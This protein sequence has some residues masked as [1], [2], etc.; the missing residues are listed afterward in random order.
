LGPLIKMSSQFGYFHVNTDTTLKTVSLN[1]G[2]F[3][4]G[5]TFWSK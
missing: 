2:E 4:T 1:D 3:I 5:D